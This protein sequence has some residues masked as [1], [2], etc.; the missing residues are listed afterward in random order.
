LE[1][2]ISEQVYYFFLKLRRKTM[3]ER[4]VLVVAIA[5]A[6]MAS[7]AWAS[8][9]PQK[10]NAAMVSSEGPTPI[11]MTVRL[12][13]QPPDINNIYWKTFQERAK[14]KLDVTWIP[15]S[16]YNT[17][18]NLILSSN[19]IPE[20]LVANL[21][22]NLNNPGF[23]SAVQHNAFWDLTPVLGDFSKYPNLKKNS[24]PNSWV[25]SR[26]LG[27]NYGIPRTTSQWQGAPMIRKDLV[28]SVGKKMPVTMAEFLDVIEAVVKANPQMI[29]IT[30]KQDFILNS[31][32]GLASGFGGDE[33]YFDSDGGLI[34]NKLTPAF[35]KFIA[36]MRDAYARGL[37]SKEFSVM[38]P[39]QATDYFQTGMSVA[40]L[41]ES[42]RWCYP[43]Q[44]SIREKT[45]NQK[46]E[47]MFV[48]P[49]EGDPG[50]Y[51][52]GLSTGFNDSF[53]ISKKTS[54]AKMLKVMDY[55]ERTST[56]EFYE[57]TTYGIEGVHW[58]KD[59]NGYRVVTPQREKD[60]GSTSPWQVLPGC[61]YPYQKIDST[62]APAE[63]NAM[64]QKA[65]DD[66]GYAELNTISPFSVV[67]SAKWVQAWP[68]Y[69]SNWAAKATQAVTGQISM[70][71]YQ[72]YVDTINKDPDMKDAYKEFAD[73]YHMIY[74]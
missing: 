31:N 66:S 62:A 27:K 25:T 59:A 29:G 64:M 35:T 1:T 49:L 17:K 18:L 20:V 12:F 54:E 30:S 11:Q 26:V 6:I 38:K 51:V 61:Y 22:N 4:K 33:P 57:L 16:D 24:A 55:F 63:Y 73:N 2:E 34:Y 68:K 19:D 40:F 8:G 9:S 3:K 67:T 53:F 71:E 72:A 42:A 36:F 5:L 69:Q 21:S 58:N 43:F 70:T 46:A 47:V 13:E 15:D 45:G 23:L 60:L 52:G 7:M 56:P 41:N 37:L 32:G 74:D 44:V 50:K 65:F 39:T 28:E 14:V 48:N 10:Q